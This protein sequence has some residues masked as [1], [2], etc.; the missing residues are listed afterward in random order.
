MNDI[1]IIVNNDDDGA[2]YTDDD[3]C[4]TDDNV[5]DSDDVE[6]NLFSQLFEQTSLIFA[7]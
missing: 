2:C 3:A 4:Y 7:L 6:T 5:D 1:M